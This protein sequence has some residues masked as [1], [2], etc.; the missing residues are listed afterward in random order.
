MNDLLDRFNPPTLIDTS[1]VIYHAIG[2]TA[3]TIVCVVGMMILIDK[4]MK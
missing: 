3:V 2:L 4:V 1:F